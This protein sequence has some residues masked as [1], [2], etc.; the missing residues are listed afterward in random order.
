MPGG[1]ANA[2]RGSATLGPEATAVRGRDTNSYKKMQKN[3]SRRQREWYT[4][5]TIYVGT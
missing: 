4:V 5:V 2:V 1:G 3:G